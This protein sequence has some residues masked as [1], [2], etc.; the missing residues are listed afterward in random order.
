MINNR[1]RVYELSQ[2]AYQ[3]GDYTGWFEK[4]YAE[5]AGNADAIPW[6]DRELN[7]WLSDWI[8]SWRGSANEQSKLVLQD[9]R[10]LVVGCGLGDDAEYLA[11]FGAK[12]T[13]FDLSQT[14]ID[15]CHQRF[16]DSQVNYQVV[17]LFTAPA[18]WKLSFDLVIEIYTIQAL[19]ANIRP[20]AI[21]CIGNFV[22]PNGKLLVVCRGRNSEDACD[23]LPFPLTQ[24]ELNRFT[25]SG[26]T[27]VS[28]EDFIDNL[29]SG[30]PRRFR[31]VYQRLD[32]T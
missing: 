12:V 5:A 17:D 15:W 14:A 1:S 4:L 16:P 25:T 24:D 7:Y 21:D 11:Q 26:L 10:V 19:P 13:A 30:S 27:Q 3:Q 29:E 31:T 2:A 18:D 8:L 9:R 32:N 20:Q 28:F 22:A 6:A 23:N